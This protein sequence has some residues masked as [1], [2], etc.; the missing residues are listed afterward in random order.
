[1]SK[2]ISLNPSPD[3]P[4]TRLESPEQI[5][6]WLDKQRRVAAMMDAAAAPWQREIKPGD[7]YFQR[8]EHGDGTLLDIFGMVLEP[9]GDEDRAIMAQVPMRRLV[10]AWS[11]DCPEGEIGTLHVA[12]VWH[13]LTRDQFELAAVSGWA[14]PVDLAAHYAGVRPRK[15]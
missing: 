14:L 3:L 5:R 15:A 10:R 12:A 9:N 8:F 11:K 1:M 13:K 6:D 4:I 2:S 7:F